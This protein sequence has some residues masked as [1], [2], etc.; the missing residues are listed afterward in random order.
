MLAARARLAPRLGGSLPLRCAAFSSASRRRRTSDQDF[1][2]WYDTR[3]RSTTILSVRK[4]DK[5]VCVPM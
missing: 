5:V 3:C 2:G 4:D 1:G